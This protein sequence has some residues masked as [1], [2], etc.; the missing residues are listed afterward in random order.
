M[1]KK[2]RI[3]LAIICF[4]LITLLF[5]GF[6]GS[7]NIWFSWL[8]KMQLIPALLAASFVIVAAILL[9][10]LLFGR[11]YCSI[12][13]P[14]GVYQ[15]GVSWLAEKTKKN[16]YKFRENRKMLR[17]SIAFA[18]ALLFLLG[19]NNIS[20]LIEP[21]SIFGRIASGIF[22]FAQPIIFV[23][24]AYFLII[25]LIALFFGRGYCNTVC[26]V[27]TILS[28]VAKYSIFKP[29]FDTEKC[30][31]CGLCEKNCR[32]SA[33][34]SK[35]HVIDYSKCTTCFN[36]ISKCNKNAMVYGFMKNKVAEEQ[37]DTPTE[38]DND[39]NKISRKTFLATVA[40]IAAAT[41]LYSPKRVSGKGLEMF[42]GKEEPKRKTPLKPAGSIS[43]INFASR[44]TGCQLCVQSCPN[45]ILRPSTSLVT[46]LQPEMSFDNNYCDPSCTRCSSVCPAGAINKI[47]PSQK[48][49]IQIGHAVFISNNCLSAH[50]GIEC[51]LCSMQCPTGAITMVNNAPVVNE[52]VCIGCGLCE[53]SCPAT[54]FK[55]IYVEGNADHL[56]L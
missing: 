43:L 18:F 29:H 24:I 53:I 7:F 36:C 4:T 28:V 46:F 12:I 5:V 54:P 2:I 44:C 48:L 15:D 42:T 20:I 55:A 34:D 19:Y 11:V 50:D 25:T 3:V 40:T 1:L 27:G 47:T 14:L 38:P 51:G 35:N 13:C 32:C 21:Y 37:T 31:S 22:S 10:T 9:T 8:A 30:I 52:R 16:R 33:I 26:P 23:S 41:A 56:E 17:Y 49:S 6:S 45:H 39:D